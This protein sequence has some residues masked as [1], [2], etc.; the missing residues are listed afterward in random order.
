[1]LQ[2]YGPGCSGTDIQG[3]QK[4]G[5][6]CGKAEGVSWWMES[7]GKSQGQ[8]PRGLR[9]QAP[10]VLAVGLPE[11]LHSPCY[12]QCFSTDFHSLVNPDQVERDFFHWRQTVHVTLCG[13]V[14]VLQPHVVLSKCLEQS[15]RPKLWCCWTEGDCSKSVGK[16]GGQFINQSCGLAR[17]APFLPFYWCKCVLEEI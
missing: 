3:L 5:T 12:T 1:M 17:N 9:P 14:L 13:V 16:E 6:M 8:N 2:L 10:R 7:L 11:G 4:S 15:S